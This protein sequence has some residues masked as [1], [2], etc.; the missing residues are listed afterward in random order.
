MATEPEK[1]GRYIRIPLGWMA[2]PSIM[3]HSVVYVWLTIA[4]STAVAVIVSLFLGREGI[5]SSFDILKDAIGLVGVAA[6]AIVGSKLKEKV[7]SND[8]TEDS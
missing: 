7:P 5:A 2:N 6:A 1:N 3:L 8:D 4:G